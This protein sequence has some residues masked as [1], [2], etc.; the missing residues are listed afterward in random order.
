MFSFPYDK[1]ILYPC[2]NRVGHS[3]HTEVYGLV[4]D[5]SFSLANG[6]PGE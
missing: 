5:R 3:P 2:P 1:V 4:G 6:S